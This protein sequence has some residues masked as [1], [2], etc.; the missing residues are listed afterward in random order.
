MK[1]GSFQSKNFISFEDVREVKPTKKGRQA[2]I[3]YVA[4][5]S[6]T[7]VILQ[8]IGSKSNKYRGEIQT[9]KSRHKEFYTLSKNLKKDDATL[10]NLA[11][12]TKLHSEKLVSMI[13]N[14]H[15]NKVGGIS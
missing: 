14:T 1:K 6:N 13:S 9:L 15:T 4:L 8:A 5:D 3:R 7:F 2:R 12:L 10:D 11:N